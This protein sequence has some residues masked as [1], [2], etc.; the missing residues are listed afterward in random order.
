MPVSRNAA[1]NF[2][3]CHSNRKNFLTLDT[4]KEIWDAILR[5]KL[6]TTATG[7]AVASGIFLL[8]V[9][10][11][12]SNGIIHTM[13]QNMEGLALDAVHIYPGWTTKPYHGMKA[14]R[15]IQLDEG[16]RQMSEQTFAT[17]VE[18]SSATI[19]QSELYAAV[20]KN[21][22]SVSV[23]GIFPA[24][25]DVY[26][27][28]LLRGRF[29]N[30]LDMREQR[31][32]AVIDDETA[33]YLYGASRS[34]IGQTLRLNGSI[35]TVVGITQ[36][37]FS[38]N[39][40][41][42]YAPFTT[43]R[44]MFAK[45]RD[46]DELTLK[47]KNLGTQQ[48]NN[49]FKTNYRAALAARHDFDQGDE[50]AVFLWSTAEESISIHQAGSVLHTSFWV[51]GIL[52]LLSGVV[53][54][55]NIMLITVKERTHE[56]GIRKAL[57]ARPW[58]IIGMVMLESVL[59]TTASGYVGMVLGIGFCQWM[60]TNA[61]GQMIDIGIAQQKV[62]IDPTVDLTTCIQ[63]TIVMITAGALAGFFPARRAAKVKPIEALRG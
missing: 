56:F 41:S 61:G 32:V 46:I 63:A 38:F 12:A 15:R 51:L 52:T 47:T 11:G 55:S 60:D 27:V 3:W 28:K 35:F 37:N 19:S 5:N 36:K 13:N 25:Q 62:F 2:V 17:N 26:G 49:Q 21:Y 31:K 16:D 50:G 23:E 10:L 44:T 22:A 1:N 6:R 57:G 48:A 43:I 39:T 18:S 7:I 8:I 20:G 29:I 59:I 34:A 42:L 33:E 40:S 45:G 54:V 14:G 58:N 53:G 9:L 4:L 24:Y 30:D